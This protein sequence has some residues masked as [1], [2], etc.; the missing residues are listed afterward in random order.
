MNNRIYGIPDKDYFFDNWIFIIVMLIVF[1]PLGFLLLLRKKDLHRRNVFEVGNTSI[2]IGI[3]FFIVGAFAIFFL[4]NI[5]VTDNLELLNS[6]NIFKIYGIIVFVFGIL[7]KIK[8]MHYKEYI[9]YVVNDEIKDIDILSKKTNQ[10]PIKTEKTLNELIKKNYL[11]NYEVKDNE[12]KYVKDEEI[13]EDYGKYESTSF[14]PT[15]NKIIETNLKNSKSYPSGTIMHCPNCGANN[16]ISYEHSKCT[17]CNSDLSEKR[18]QIIQ[19]RYR[20]QA[21]EQKEKERQEKIT[22]PVYQ[23][24]NY[25]PY[26]KSK[27]YSEIIPSVIFLILVIII[28]LFM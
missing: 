1:F 23:T 11:T 9:H 25:K 17:Y 19:E 13:I 5:V 26:D 6:I 24:T 14:H 12:I 3:S 20:K 22:N 18:K 21:Y 28:S 8:A 16:K 7:S 10:K 2:I 15:V 27:D 4:K